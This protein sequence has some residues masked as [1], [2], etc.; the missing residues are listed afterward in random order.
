[1]T[2]LAFKGETPAKKVNRAFVWLQHRRLLKPRTFLN[3]PHVFLASRCAGDVDT[4]LGMKVPPENVWAV[5]KD[6]DEYEHLFERQDRQKF[7]LYTEKVELVA[8]RFKSELRSVY[9]DYCGNLQG[10][11][12]TTAR[13]VSRLPPRTALSVTVFLGREHNAPVDREAALLQE[14]RAHT[15][16]AVTLVQSVLYVSLDSATYSSPMGTWTFYLGPWPSRSKM[17]FDLTSYSTGELKRLVSSQGLVSSLWEEKLAV[18]QIRS[19]AATQAN[20]TR[21]PIRSRRRH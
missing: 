6:R 8:A 13:V 14:I 7:S 3:T 1:M 5:E 20:I 9:L 19:R 10:T 12:G 4:L 18:C 21:R 15:H 2:N 16:H 17:Q 11:K